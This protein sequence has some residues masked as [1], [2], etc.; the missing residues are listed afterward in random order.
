MLAPANCTTKETVI[1]VSLQLNA[2]PPIAARNVKLSNWEGL[3]KQQFPIPTRVLVGHFVL[4]GVWIRVQENV[5][6]TLIKVKIV[7]KIAIAKVDY[8]ASVS[9]LPSVSRLAFQTQVLTAVVTTHL[10][11]LSHVAVLV[12]Y[13]IAE[14]VSIIGVSLGVVIA[15]LTWL[16]NLQIVM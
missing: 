1:L 12:T 5:V 10:R 8:I 13:A 14:S 16:A 15:R 2:C 3:A 4:N 6:P 9:V 7:C 11:V